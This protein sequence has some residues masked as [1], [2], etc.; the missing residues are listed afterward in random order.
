MNRKKILLVLGIPDAGME[1][2]KTREDVDWEILSDDSPAALHAALKTAHGVTL[3]LTPFG[4]AES[5]AAPLLEGVARIGVGYDKVDV[6]TLTARNVPLLVTGTANSVSVA[7]QAFAFMIS[8]SKSEARF[9]RMV[10]AGDWASRARDMPEDLAGRTVL[11][12]GFGRIGTRT[13]KRCAAFDMTVLVHDPYVP[14]ATIRAAGHEPAEDLDAALPR[15]DFVTVH[16]PKTPETVG[17][18]GA[19]RLAAMKRTAYLVNTARGGIVDEAALHAALT[20]G[21]IRGA[22][23]DVFDREPPDPANPLLR[24]DNVIAMPHMAGVTKEANARMAAAAIRN[25]L[26][27]FDGKPNP[28]HVVNREVLGRR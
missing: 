17:L 18:I 13:A 10:K 5:A 27:T 14:A 23:L 2:L 28:D 1:V 15:A 19:R 22:G 11:V 20:D 24:L 7:E 8:L 12:I 16:C 26:D 9:D 25:L 4:P 6:P 21:T 3:R